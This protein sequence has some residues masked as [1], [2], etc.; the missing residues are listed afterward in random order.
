MGNLVDY[1]IAMGSIPQVRMGCFYRSETGEVKGIRPASAV[2]DGYGERYPALE[3]VISHLRAYAGEVVSTEGVGILLAAGEHTRAWS[4]YYYDKPDKDYV[5]I[6][7][8]ASEVG[9]V[10]R[11]IYRWIENGWIE[12]IQDMHG[13]VIVEIGSVRGAA[14]A[15]PIGKSFKAKKAA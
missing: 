12:C 1:C 2:E 3:R 8:A 13:E 11:T 14:I 15:V 4:R 6:K 5:T 7:E 9:V 10:P